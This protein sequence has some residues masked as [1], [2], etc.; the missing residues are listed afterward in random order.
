M[1]ANT[2]SQSY[3]ELQASVDA[4][5]IAEA[6]ADIMTLPPAKRSAAA[7]DFAEIDPVLGQKLRLSICFAQS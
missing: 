4:E 5:L 7:D 2:Y 3:Q 1:D 6:L